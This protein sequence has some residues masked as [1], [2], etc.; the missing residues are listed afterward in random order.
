MD[1]RLSLVGEGW[2]IPGDDENGGLVFGGVRFLGKEMTIDLGIV[3]S[4]ESDSS[5]DEAQSDI[6]WDEDES[7]SDEDEV[8]WFPYIDFVWNF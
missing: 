7:D 6:S 8:G 5:K 2:F 3:T 4:F 1:R